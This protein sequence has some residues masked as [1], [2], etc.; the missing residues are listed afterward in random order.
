MTDDEYGYDGDVIDV[1][2]ATQVACVLPGAGLVSY[3]E[4]VRWLA[5][6]ANGEWWGYEVQPAKNALGRPSWDRIDF[7]YRAC[8]IYVG[9]ENEEW[10]DSLMRV[11]GETISGG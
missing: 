1:A 9:K 3:P 4:W 6:D 2:A 11:W 7:F 10:K 8:L 5:Q